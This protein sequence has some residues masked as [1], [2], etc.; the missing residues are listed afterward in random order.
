MPR[1]R[2]PSGDR[3]SAFVPPE[4]GGDAGATYSVQPASS[5]ALKEVIYARLWS[6][7]HFRTADVQGD[8]LGKK[9]CTTCRRPTS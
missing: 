9:V 5:L 1:A 3:A 2:F 4:S 8:V 7:I 6:G